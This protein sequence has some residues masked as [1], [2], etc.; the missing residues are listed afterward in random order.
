SYPNYPSYTSYS[1]YPN[2]PSYP[3]YPTPAIEFSAGL[4][5]KGQIEFISAK[6]GTK[7]ILFSKKADL[8]DPEVRQVYDMVSRNLG[9][10][11]L[12]ASCCQGD[13]NPAC[14]KGQPQKKNSVT[15]P[16]SGVQ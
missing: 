9:A 4:S 2:Y 7:T 10:Y 16:A 1:S 6:K 11:I 14:S 15:K 8:K 5:D 13:K 3:S 12:G